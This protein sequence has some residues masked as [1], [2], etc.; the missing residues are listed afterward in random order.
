MAGV[1]KV[2]MEINVRR[3]MDYNE[4]NVNVISLLKQN[5]VIDERTTRKMIEALNV[6]QAG[7]SKIHTETITQDG[8]TTSIIGANDSEERTPE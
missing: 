7:Y 1:F 5:L 3:M 8:Y 6:L 2:V 4:Y